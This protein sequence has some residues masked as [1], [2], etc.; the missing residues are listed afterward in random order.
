MVVEARVLLA[1]PADEPDV[2]VDVAVELR[3]DAL[4]GVVLDQ[5]APE[6][7][8]AAELD[9]QL[10][11]EG[12]PEVLVAGQPLG[13]PG[14]D[15]AHTAD[16]TPSS[17]RRGFSLKDHGRHGIA[18][19]PDR[20]ERGRRIDHRDVA[21]VDELGDPV[22]GEAEVERAPPVRRRVEEDVRVHRGPVVHAARAHPFE[23]DR[24]TAGE[25]REDYGQVGEPRG[26]AREPRGIGGL[27][28]RAVVDDRAPPGRRVARKLARRAR[29][30]EQE[31]ARRAELPEQRVD[32]ADELPCC[33]A[34]AGE[35]GPTDPGG[36]RL[37]P[38]GRRSDELERA[39]VIRVCELPLGIRQVP[40]RHRDQGD[41]DPVTIEQRQAGI[42]IVVAEVDLRVELAGK[43]KHAPVEARW[44]ASPGER[45]RERLRPEMLMDVE[46]R[47]GG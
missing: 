10:G 39:G 30:H 6:V 42:E 41:V 20:G 43:P 16:R 9:G 7:S 2:E 5:L 22:G 38:A 17:K 19:A 32:S 29:V 8:L 18:E 15:V 26:V 36:E 23:L 33:D 11:E 21:P 12:L 37:D 4:V 34:R 35:P 40:G 31:L 27:H 3:V 46:R 45:S 28:L 13:D 47:H 24:R 25:D 44:L 1:V 14:R